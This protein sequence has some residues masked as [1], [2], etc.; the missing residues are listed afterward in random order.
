MKRSSLI[1]F[2]HDHWWFADHEFMK[3]VLGKNLLLS[4]QKGHKMLVAKVKDS[5]MMKL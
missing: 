5:C 2:F 3:R 4:L 1:F